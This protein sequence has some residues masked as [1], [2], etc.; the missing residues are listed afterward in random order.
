M[1]TNTVRTRILIISDTHSRKPLEGDEQYDASGARTHAYSYP[2][3]EA[4]VAIHCGDLTAR[5][6]TA[7]YE[8]TFSMLRALSAPLKLVIPGNHDRALDPVHWS[9]Y[10]EWKEEIGTQGP[11][12]DEL[13]ARPEKVRAIVDAAAA[14][15]VLFL[16]EGCHDFTLANGAKLRTY[17]SPWTPEYGQWGFQYQPG[18]HRFNIPKGVD[19]VFTHGPPKGVLD[20]TN[21]NESAGCPM[22]LDAICRARPKIHC[23]GHIHEAWGAKLAAWKP[24]FAGMAAIDEDKS[25]WIDKWDFHDTSEEREVALQAMREAKCRRVDLKGESTIDGDLSFT[26]G[27]HTLFVNAAIMD[28]AYRPRNAPWLIDI[29]LPLAEATDEDTTQL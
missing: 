10:T 9:R 3:P 12:L 21:I 18:F 27:Q 15:N 6:N 16:D 17:A 5:S 29:D 1:S 19:V 25:R 2:L 13:R 14:D 24:L 20:T 7:E 28:I 22:L 11:A 8:S 26:P 23:F 4:D